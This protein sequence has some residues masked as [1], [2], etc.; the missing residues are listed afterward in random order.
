MLR[1]LQASPYWTPLAGWLTLQQQLQL[2]FAGHSVSGALSE[3]GWAALSGPGALTGS[4]QCLNGLGAAAQSGAW[5][6]AQTWGG[7]APEWGR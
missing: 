1:Q 5:E 2:M 3:N 4:G 7:G 6:A